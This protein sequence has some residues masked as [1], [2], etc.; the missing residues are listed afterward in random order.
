MLV[1]KNLQVAVWEN[2][3]MTAWLTALDTIPGTAP[4]AGFKLGLWKTDFT[5]TPQSDIADFVAAD[6]SGYATQ[7]VTPGAVIEPNGFCLGRKV[8]GLWT[9]SNPTPFVPNTIYGMYAMNAAAT[10]WYMAWRF[11]TP[12]NFASNLD[13]LIAFAVMSIAYNNTTQWG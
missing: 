2:D 6:F 3:F 10:A 9:P 13:S 11:P 8:G 1:E 7:S 12:M 5:P 4:L